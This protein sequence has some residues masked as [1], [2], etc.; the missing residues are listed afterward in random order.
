[1]H[2]GYEVDGRISHESALDRAITGLE[3]VPS[4]ELARALAVRAEWLGRQDRVAECDLAATQAIELAQTLDLPTIEAMGWAARTLAAYAGGSIEALAE[5]EERAAVAYQ[6]GGEA[7]Q[8]Y[9]CQIFFARDLADGADPERG[10]AMLVGLRGATT[11]AGFPRA[12]RTAAFHLVTVLVNHGRLEEAGSLIEAL[13]EE[14]PIDHFTGLGAWVRLLVA[15]GDARAALDLEPRW[16][17]SVRSYASTPNYED[18]VTDVIVLVA[19]GLIAEAAEVAGEYARVMEGSDA[20]VMHGCVAHAGYL[21]LDAA[22]RA[23]LVADDVLEAQMAAMLARADR[24]VAG[25]SLRTIFGVSILTARALQAEL[26]RARSVE[27]WRAA[28]DATAHI[29]AGLA[30]WPRLRLQQALLD[31]GERDEVRAAL[32][33]VVADATAMGMNGVLA[34]AVRLAR[35]HRIPVPGDNR[36]SR[37]DVLTARER[38]VLD[39]LATGATNKAIAERLYISEKTVS[40]H[41][42]NLL[43]K[44]GVTNRTEA[45]AVA[46][47]VAPVD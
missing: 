17:A 18:V 6:R 27:L 14:G 12:A 31:A 45:A 5:Y 2:T 24:A 3:G 37:L 10:L 32:P 28:C 16:M 29:G 33:A 19:N 34:E 35:R 42:T 8:A 36:P 11:A 20:P 43:A 26:R 21:V 44:L 1:V 23:G 25:R 40:V 22:R 9:R 38:E 7:F 13:L 46:R 4:E 30:L 15:R 47:D 39:V 41:V